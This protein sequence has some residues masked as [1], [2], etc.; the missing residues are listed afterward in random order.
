MKSFL[1]YILATICGL[2]IFTFLAGIVFII[3]LAGMAASGSPSAQVKENSVFV[4]KMDG[5]VQERGEEGSPLDV[6]MNSNDMSV[7]GLEDILASIKKAKENSDIKG[8]Y[9]EGG[10]TSF[11]SPAT[12]QQIRDALKDFKK[13]GKWIIAFADNYT[14]SA[15]YVASVADS[16]YL[17][18]TGMIELKGIGG[19]REFITGLYEKIGVK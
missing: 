18:P 9:I 17:A 4:L 16:V 3:S 15:Y 14:Q 1:K 2:V 11:D 7:M 19:K 13:S 12:A 5:T 6:L 10:L 8:I